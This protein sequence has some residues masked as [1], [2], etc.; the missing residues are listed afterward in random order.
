M[1]MVRVMEQI[2]VIK[3]RSDRTKVT[4]FYALRP[5]NIDE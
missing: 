2:E 5:E 1:K 3:L 4:R